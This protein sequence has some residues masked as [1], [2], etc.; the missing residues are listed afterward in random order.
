MSQRDPNQKQEEQKAQLLTHSGGPL[1]LVSPL[2]PSLSFKMTGIKITKHA[3]ELMT[4]PAVLTAWGDVLY[5]YLKTGHVWTSLPA[6]LVATVTT[7]AQIYNQ[8]APEDKHIPGLPTYLLAACSFI[9]AVP[10]FYHNPDDWRAVVSF[11]GWGM[12]F[13]L[14]AREEHLFKQRNKTSDPQKGKSSPLLC[15]LD[16]KLGPSAPMFL[17]PAIFL[18]LPKPRLYFSELLQRTLFD[19]C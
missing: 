19:M 1:P 18:Q 13:G 6:I 5:A 10:A 7:S 17:S 15:F 16:E 2:S 8:F 4:N 11:I 9:E 14:L 12:G 3:K